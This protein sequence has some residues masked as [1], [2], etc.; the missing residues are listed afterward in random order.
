MLKI[1]QKAP[2]FCLKDS[3]G[4]E[5]C[6]SSFQGKKVILYFYPKD[7]TSGCTKQALGYRDLYK[8]FTEKNAVVIGISKDSVASHKK[9]R[10]A[11]DLPFILLADPELAAIKD[12]DV[13]HEKTL[14][15]RKYFGVVRTTYVIDE[16]GVIV[17]AE[18]KVDA[19][20]NAADV[21][22]SL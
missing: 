5:V 19:E 8:E 6:L 15:G 2:E 22:C 11:H 3:Y 7:L 9:F 21:L 18:E 20:K 1:N 10:E 4:N 17:S 12:Y 13:W 16:K 14:Y